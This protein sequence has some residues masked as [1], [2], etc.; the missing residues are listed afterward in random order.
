MSSNR[1]AL[2]YLDR[3]RLK[4]L[5]KGV[6]RQIHEAKENHAGQRAKVSYVIF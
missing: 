4:K 1:R 5:N 6:Y 3:H 2:D